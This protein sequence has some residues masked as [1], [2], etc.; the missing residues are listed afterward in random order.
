MRT[1]YQILLFPY[2]KKDDQI[3]YALFKREDMDVWQGIA[4]GGEGD[5]KPIDAVKREA[6]EEGEIPLDSNYIKLA[7]IATIPVTNICGFKWGNDI[8]VIPEFSFGVELKSTKINIG[9]EHTEFQWLSFEEAMKK[10][11]WDSNKTAL[12]ELN[13]RLANKKEESAKNNIHIIMKNIQ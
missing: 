3:H 13:Y 1:P 2:M 10:L 7:S 4:G 5:E 12:W 8:A 6:L 11:K 9:H